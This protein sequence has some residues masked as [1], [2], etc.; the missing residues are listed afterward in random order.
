MRPARPIAAALALLAAACASKPPKLYLIE[1][2]P[3]AGGPQQA[4]ELY[5]GVARVALPAYASDARIARRSEGGRLILDDDHRWAEPPEDSL[6][7]VLSSQIARELG[8]LSVSEPFPRGFKLDIRVASTFDQFLLTE[9]GEA[10]MTGT[11]SYI[12]GDGRR[13]LKIEPFSV[14]TGVTGASMGDYAA[15]VSVNLAEI[16]GQIAGTVEDLRSDAG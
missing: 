5:V 12:T 6:T 3:N 15:A 7:R 1:D 8:G 13:T 4:R 9:N 10:V 16:G 11:I 14:K 2:A